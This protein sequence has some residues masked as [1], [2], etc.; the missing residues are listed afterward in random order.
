MIAC[1]QIITNTLHVYYKYTTKPKRERKLK[2]YI[3]S[4]ASRS[5]LKN[6]SKKVK[7]IIFIFSK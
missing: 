2:N 5:L 1:D 7:Y 6:V 3:F 4:L